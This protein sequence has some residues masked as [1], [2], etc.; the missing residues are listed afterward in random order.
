MAEQNAVILVESL[1]KRYRLG[2]RLKKVDALVD[3]SFDVRKG[4]VFGFV[5]P[6]GAGKTTTIR[7]LMGLS[8]PTAGRCSIFGVPVPNRQAR[9][10]IGFLPE[11]PNFYEY[12]NVSEMLA[13]AGTLFG[14]S[15]AVHRRR[16]GELVERLGLA[17]AVKRPLRRF[18]KGML[19]RAG[20]AQ[21]LINDPE[22]LVLDEPMSGL[23]PIGRKDVR[24][25]MLQL[26]DAGKTIFFSTHLLGDV[27]A[28]CD[29]VAIISRGRV[30]EVGSVRRLLSPELLGVEVLLRARSGAD[31]GS[32]VPE[33]AVVRRIDDEVAVTLRPEV[34]LEAFLGKACEVAQVISVTPR[35]ESLED[36]FVRRMQPQSSR[37]NTDSDA[38]SD[39]AGRVPAHPEPNWSSK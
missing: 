26:R 12:L 33:G 23:D 27:E 17:S 14:L 2:V 38:S 8:N 15:A 7:I 21:A 31:L 30:H 13:L 19:Q 35:R 1:A 36:L 29:R 24:D 34:N 32:V 9:T 37:P 6:N 10:K 3:A 20:L 25:L 5:G 4:E 39:A 28:I 18:S 16:A 22:L 11:T